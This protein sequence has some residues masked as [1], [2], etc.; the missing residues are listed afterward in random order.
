MHQAGVIVS[1][2]G[3]SYRRSPIEVDRMIGLGSLHDLID[4]SSPDLDNFALLKL[5]RDSLGL[6]NVAYFAQH[7]PP[8]TNRE[9][10]IEVTYP[11]AWI[12]H[13]KA[14]KYV[15]IDPVLRDPMK[16]IMPTDWSTLPRATPK[17]RQLFADAEFFGVGHQGLTI[18]IRGPRGEL[19]FFSV[20]MD[21][22]DPEWRL[23]LR[24]HL[25]TLQIVAHFY[26]D[27]VLE[28]HGIKTP[29]VHL[30]P[31][32]LDVLRWAANGKAVQD[33]AT[34]LRLSS[35]TVQTYLEMAR[36]KLQALN[37]SHAVARAISLALIPPPD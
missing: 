35:H 4:Q 32:E 28:Q 11:Q 23:F 14:K 25:P 36:T 29:H 7:L 22:S 16:T 34:I 30:S 2:K 3:T 12:E 27:R 17:V 15:E 5:V 31:R 26:H 9:P 13:Y 18:P 19:A 6:T 24:A 8:L 20:T 1:F 37:T 10:Y 33:T 21:I